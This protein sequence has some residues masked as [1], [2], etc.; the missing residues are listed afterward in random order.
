MRGPP[1]Q[2]QTHRRRTLTPRAVLCFHQMSLRG[3][4]MMSVTKV[5][6][7][8]LLQHSSFPL[9][10]CA[11]ERS[12]K[13]YLLGL[14][15]VFPFLRLQPW[16]P[17]SSPNVWIYGKHCGSGLSASCLPSQCASNSQIPISFLLFFFFLNVFI[18]PHW[19]SVT[20]CRI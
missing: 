15:P 7:M 9:N 12:G 4:D 20:A 16:V 11:R 1:F 17:P 8:M 2:G 10:T 18:W 19:V 5:D 3:Q 14:L 6:S 13:I